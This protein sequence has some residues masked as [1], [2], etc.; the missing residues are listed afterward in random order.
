MSV[1]D[2]YS[3]VKPSKKPKKVERTTFSQEDATKFCGAY[4]VACVLCDYQEVIS[5]TKQST[6]INEIEFLQGYKF[7]FETV[8]RSL[9]QEITSTRFF[10]LEENYAFYRARHRGIHISKISDYCEKTILVKNY[11]NILKQLRA[12]NTEKELINVLKTIQENILNPCGKIFHKYIRNNEAIHASR[13]ELQDI[14]AMYFSLIYINQIN[15]GMP[16][17]FHFSLFDRVSKQQYLKSFDGFK[18]SSQYVW[19]VL[20]KDKYETA[21]VSKLHTSDSYDG[22]VSIKDV[23][24]GEA[25]ILPYEERTDFDSYFHKINEQI[26]KNL[27]EKYAFS[28]FRDALFFFSKRVPK[29]VLK[30]LLIP[31]KK[32]DL[33]EQEILDETLFWYECE[34]LDSSKSHIFN[35]VT[36]FVKL[37]M[38]VVEFKAKIGDDEKAYVTKFVHPQNDTDS[39]YSYG[40]LIQSYG[41]IG[42][43]FSGWIIFYDCCG[44]Y[45]GFSGQEHAHAEHFIKEYIDSESVELRD[46]SISKQ[47]FSE[48]LEGNTT[49]RIIKSE[50]KIIHEMKCK[51]NEAKGMLL[52]LLAYYLNCCEED[53]SVRW[54]H[55]EGAEIDIVVESPNDIRFIECKSNAASCNLEAEIQKLK[56][57][58]G[59]YQTSKKKSM[60]FWFWEE[61][62]PQTTESLSSQKVDFVV[63]KN[64][65]KGTPKFS[66]RYNKL[67][68]IFTNTE[69]WDDIDNPFE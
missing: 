2:R 57:K 52:E 66:K 59:A 36:A 1:S 67:E 45:S 24:L 68:T 16:M 62:T 63:L 17:G 37:L 8:L 10:D 53:L 19:K 32:P 47:H 21:I 34:V 13:E 31:Q 46:L 11:N 18:Y 25:E 38:G 69:F 6:E 40:I 5:F 29:T 39:D 3:M 28:S 44:D 4:R 14:A 51:L 26:I 42:S 61:P 58:M 15:H 27:E 60:E 55:D 9:L 41:S 49:E 30:S 65:L 50:N 33:T 12:S 20:L 22:E 48:F 35:G 54:S 43:D 7:I 64:K 23:M 56:N